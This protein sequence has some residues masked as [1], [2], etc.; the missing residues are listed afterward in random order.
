MEGILYAQ[1]ACPVDRRDR[2]HR[3]AVAPPFREQYDLRL[4]DVRREDRE[5]R[6][7]EGV[8]AAIGRRWTPPQDARHYFA[9]CGYG[10]A[11]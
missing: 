1:A 3:G 4:V 7:V 9:H 8:E 6:V 2:I 11:K 5:G 10:T